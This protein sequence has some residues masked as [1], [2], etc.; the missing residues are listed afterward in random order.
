MTIYFDFRKTNDTGDAL[1][2]YTF[3]MISN[4]HMVIQFLTKVNLTNTGSFILIL[5]GFCLSAYKE[6]HQDEFS[7]SN[8][9]VAV[10][11][12]VSPQQLR[13]EEFRL[14]DKYRTIPLGLN[15]Y[16]V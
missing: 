8:F 5:R 1:K 11:K 9:S 16:K 13:R 12:K 10:I 7:F 3:D 2:M 6:V 15:R 14:I 4:L